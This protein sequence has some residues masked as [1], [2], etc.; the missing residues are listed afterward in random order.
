MPSLNT[1]SATQIEQLRYSI[2]WWQ[3][4]HLFL[5]RIDDRPLAP[6]P[7]HHR[8]L[9][10]NR[11]GPDRAFTHLRKL[12]QNGVRSHSRGLGHYGRMTLLRGTGRP[13]TSGATAGGLFA[14]PS[15]GPHCEPHCDFT[16][17]DESTTRIDEKDTAVASAAAAPRRVARSRLAC[18]L[19]TPHTSRLT[20]HTRGRVCLTLTSCTHPLRGTSLPHTPRRTHTSRHHKP[21]KDRQD[22]GYQPNYTA[23]ARRTDGIPGHLL[24]LLPGHLMALTDAFQH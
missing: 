4:N 5:T 8:T 16:Q 11:A 22:V 18:L 14:K 9:G 24:T 15:L 7:T 19:L 13:Y 10:L 1:H 21:N 2:Y 3:R 20:P 23:P 6:K 17:I 12:S